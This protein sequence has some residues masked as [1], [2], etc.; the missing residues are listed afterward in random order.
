MF[1][2]CFSF[3]FSLWSRETFSISSPS[4]SAL[5]LSALLI[6]DSTVLLVPNWMTVGIDT[7][8]FTETMCG[9]GEMVSRPF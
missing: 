3:L 7:Y 6:F 8:P 1:G 5:S 4:F 2:L 9:S